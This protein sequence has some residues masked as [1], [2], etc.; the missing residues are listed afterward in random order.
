MELVNLHDLMIKTKQGFDSNLFD[1][2]RTLPPSFKE[3]V[4]DF[5]GTRLTY[6]DYTC[7]LVERTP[8][9]NIVFPN[10]WFYIA[11]YMTDYYHMILAYKQKIFDILKFESLEAAKKYFVKSLIMTK[12]L[13]NYLIPPI[14]TSTIELG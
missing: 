4:P 2:E 12:W 10:Q 13:I 1:S 11:A 7:V 5:D 8:G 14:I 6:L 9:L 3:M